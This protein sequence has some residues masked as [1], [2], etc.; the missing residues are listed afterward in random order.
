MANP[1]GRP[2][3]PYRSRVLRLPLPASEEGR[4]FLAAYQEAIK[5]AAREG[6]RMADDPTYAP[7]E[8]EHPS[9]Y[10]YRLPEEQGG[11]WVVTARGPLP[12]ELHERTEGHL[13]V[14]ADGD[15]GI[16]R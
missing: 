2:T 4:Q 15:V 7:E 1:N 14:F 16:E 13:I 10:L 8:A 9:V 5:E 6:K 12:R 3:V 11:R